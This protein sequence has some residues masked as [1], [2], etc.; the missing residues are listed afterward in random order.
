MKTLKQ[1]NPG[2]RKY[3]IV[4]DGYVKHLINTALVKQAQINDLVLAKI[5]TMHH[6]RE[7]LFDLMKVMDPKEDQKSL[8]ICGAEFHKIEAQLQTLWGFKQ[9]VNYHKFW[10]LPHCECPMLDNEDAYPRGFYGYSNACPVHGK[11]TTFIKKLEEDLHKLPLKSSTAI[12]NIKNDKESIPV[13]KNPISFKAKY[14]G[15][16]LLIALMFS[17]ALVAIVV[18][19]EFATKGM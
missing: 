16:A 14:I 6:E 7:D 9:D 11:V 2:L 13:F 18:F 19:Y 4:R 3:A 8:A 12:S 17:A 15:E 10:K 5:K 1:L